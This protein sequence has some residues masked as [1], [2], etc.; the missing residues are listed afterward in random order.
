MNDEISIA[1]GTSQA[2]MRAGSGG[3][4]KARVIVGF[5]GESLQNQTLD[6]QADICLV[7]DMSGSMD[8]TYGASKRT[9][10]EGV[11]EAAQM[12]IDMLG[13]RD[14]I[15]II[16]F[17]DD[18]HVLCERL[19]SNQRGEYNQA[20]QECSQ[21]YGGTNIPKAI[22]TA[23]NLLSKAP[24]ESSKRIIL[25]TDGH[26]YQKG[27]SRKRLE[28]E[29]LKEAIGAGDRGQVIDALGFGDDYSYEFLQEVVK[30]TGGR[31]EAA[32]SETEVKGVFADSLRGAQSVAAIQ[33]KLNFG[34]AN[35]VVV[36]ECY[37]LQPTMQFLGKPSSGKQREWTLNIGDMSRM[38]R[39]VYLLSLDMPS[40]P[41]GKLRVA[42]VELE[43]YAPGLGGSISNSE[44]LVV[45][46]L[47]D[48]SR[49]SRVDIE[50]LN[51]FKEAE[52]SR[53][54]IL[55]KE[56][57]DRGDERAVLKYFGLMI[58]QSK[59]I[60]KMEYARQLER[61]RDE[62][63]KKHQLSKEDLIQAQHSSTVS[64]SVVTDDSGAQEIDKSNLF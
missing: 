61:L 17:E 11:L 13:N 45:E 40:R 55:L 1:L 10:R 39:Y 52:L 59:E 57:Y 50:V 20:V 58:E 36:N 63:A 54:M 8:E 32:V 28:D 27:V 53:L 60:Q 44:S 51:Q 14:R 47:S 7:L 62:Y 15:S 43:C 31:T 26:P 56:N 48:E 18:A 25:L 21:L 34:F 33:A 16:G 64:T 12:I 22:G 30:N 41:E 3:E 4:L 49:Y 6:L 37:R 5:A 29:S 42:E 38:N 2:A 19:G 9:K 23:S 24:K 46:Y 35:E